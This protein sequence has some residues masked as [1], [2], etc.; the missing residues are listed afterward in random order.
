M[1]N[2]KPYTLYCLYHN[3][4]FPQ[5]YGDQIDRITFVKMDQGEYVF[6]AKNHIFLA[7]EPYFHP[8]GK[9]WVEYEFYYSLYKGYKK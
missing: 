4:V 3:Q 7:H 8:I 5:Y 6:P 9:E 1:H 2:N